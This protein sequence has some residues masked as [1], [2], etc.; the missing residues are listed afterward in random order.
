MF[1]GPFD[2]SVDVMHGPLD[3]SDVIRA[4]ALSVIAAL[5]LTL[6]KLVVGLLSG[7]LGVLSEAL[8]SGLDLVAA[9]V[10]YVA[11]KA[12]A[13]A[14]DE[15]HQYGHGKV[16]SFAALAET[17]MLW[18]TSVWIIYEAFRRILLEEWPEP[19]IWGIIVMSISI[20]VD[21]ERSRMLYKTAEE[22]GSQALE[23]DALHFSTDMIS[24][25]VVLLGL[26]FVWFGFPIGDPLA[27]LGVSIVIIYVS[28][29]LGRRAYDE[30]VDTAPEGVCEDVERICLETPGVIDVG[31]VR[32]RGSV[33]TMFIDVVVRV[34]ESEIISHAH[35]VASRIE[36]KIAE[37]YE[38]VDIMIHIE[39]VEHDDEDPD[40]YSLM[41]RLARSHSE[42]KNL[43]NV[44]IFTSGGG[45]HIAAHLEM[46]DSLTLS[47]AHKVSENFERG[48]RDRLQN[49]ESV[50]L[51]LES[52]EEED[53]GQDITDRAGDIVE[54]ARTIINSFDFISA[55]GDV[56]VGEEESGIT[57]A[58]TCTVNKDMS[59]S[60]SHG[61]SDKIEK[62]ILSR[63][64]Q[65]SSV[66][67]HL[68]PH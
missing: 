61:L 44:R 3:R 65:V 31:R 12:A 39:P 57:L 37:K 11:V 21:Y 45:I 62:V 7:S 54:T 58:V 25:S 5:A 16:E 36:D 18:V 64:P 32:V 48:L 53:V 20:V 34:K 23:A 55:C 2:W 30:L 68:E 63:I 17:I 4:A 29:N 60:E 38:N 19:T 24:S 43:H 6:M 13:K 40:V 26:F 59:L 42:I 9:G 56:V 67:V 8:H 33:T 1:R 15:D 66:T 35:D 10:T 41:Q 27:A 14:P 51:H 46:D 52:T 49:V 50:T 22:H 28:L 47:A